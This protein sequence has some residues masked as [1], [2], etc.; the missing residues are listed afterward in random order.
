MSARIR[1]QSPNLPGKQSASIQQADESQQHN[2]SGESDEYAPDIEACY[3]I[4]PKLVK[5]E[6]SD[7]RPDDADENIG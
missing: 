4:C 1:L 7:K 2:R 5:Q 6:T 3:A